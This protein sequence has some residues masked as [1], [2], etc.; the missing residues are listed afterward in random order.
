MRNNGVADRVTCL[1]GDGFHTPGVFHPRGHDLI[2]ANILANSLI[3]MAE[4]LAKVL[5]PGG[6]AILSGLIDEQAVRVE[7]AY[8]RAGLLSRR[9][10]MLDRW[11]VITL[12]QPR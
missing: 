4:Q 1:A 6:T 12:R 8:R 5:A 3:A 9:R 2:F 10:L 11:V 7:S